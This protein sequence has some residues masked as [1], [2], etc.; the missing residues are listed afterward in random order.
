MLNSIYKD[1]IKDTDDEFISD[2][3]D[4]ILLRWYQR[5]I[6]NDPWSFVLYY[7]YPWKILP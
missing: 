7:G 5:L 6:E 3:G 4:I 2:N 1:A